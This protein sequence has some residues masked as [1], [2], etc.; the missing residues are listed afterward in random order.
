MTRQAPPEYT[1]LVEDVDD[2]SLVTKPWA[3]WFS[4]L[5]SDVGVLQDASTAGYTGT[6]TLAKI[7]GGGTNG[8]LTVINGLITAVTAPT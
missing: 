7:T 4:K 3:V 5:S 1:E 6:V 2:E 8:S